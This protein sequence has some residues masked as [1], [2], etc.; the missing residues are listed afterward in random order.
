MSTVKISKELF[1]K[2]Q[3]D[4]QVLS[5]LE[6]SGVDNWDG[7]EDALAPI[8]KKSELRDRI[9]GEIETLLGELSKYIDA[10]A[11][12]EAGYGICGD[13]PYDEVFSFLDCVEEIKKELGV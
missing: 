13:E 2:L 12:W 9:E 4:Q 1:K 3:E 5:A 11:G 6:A 10:P 8:R 7:Y